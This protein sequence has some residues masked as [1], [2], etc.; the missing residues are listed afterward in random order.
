MACAGVQ[1]EASEAFEALLPSALLRLQ[2]R[3]PTT[4][5]D[6]VDALW[7]TKVD[8]LQTEAVHDL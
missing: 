5:Y 4:F 8:D 2:R 7:F 6:I 3:Q 1:H